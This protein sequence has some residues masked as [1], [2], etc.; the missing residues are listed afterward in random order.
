[1]VDIRQGELQ[2]RRRHLD[3]SLDRWQPHMGERNRGQRW[4]IVG[5]VTGPA[6]NLRIE[7]FRDS[8]LATPQ[9]VTK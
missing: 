7:W 8:L 2:I 6:R 1:M 3:V 5:R 4:W 9:V